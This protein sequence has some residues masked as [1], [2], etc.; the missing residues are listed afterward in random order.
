LIFKKLYKA[1]LDRSIQATTSN[2]RS[3]DAVAGSSLENLIVIKL[4][5]THTGDEKSKR[6]KIILLEHDLRGH[7]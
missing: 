7:R 2:Q 1:T 3:L 6:T 5:F 4:W